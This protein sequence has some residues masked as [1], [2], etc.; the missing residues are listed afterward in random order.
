MRCVTKLDFGFRLQ[1]QG[2]DLRVLFLQPL[3]DQGLVALQGVMQRLLAGDAELGQ[4][5]PTKTRLKAILNLSLI[6]LATTSRVHSAKAN[7]ICSRFFCIMPSKMCILNL[8]PLVGEPPL[9]PST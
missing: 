6:N 9:T 2:P 8:K 4:K 1:R 7:F 5:P 3:L